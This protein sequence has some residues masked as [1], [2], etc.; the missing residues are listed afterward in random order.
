MPVRTFP[1][2]AAW[3]RR[4]LLGTAA[5][6]T[7]LA[8]L[9]PLYALERRPLA[10]PL[11]F[12]AHPD[13][14]IEWWYVTGALETAEA[15]LLW[16]FQLTFFRSRT[17]VAASH[18]SRFAA[19]QLVFA[20]AAL[21]DVAARRLRHD[22]RVARAGFGI[23]EAAVGDTR[24][25]LREWSLRRDAASGTYRARLRSDGADFALDLALVGD[26]PPLLQ[27]DAGW[28][29]KGPAEEQASRYY[30][31]PQLRA[32]GTLAVDGSEH[33]VHGTAWLDHEWS[34]ALLAPDAAGWDWIGINLA[35]GGALTA[36]RLRRRDGST[37]WAGGS[38]R[39]ADGTLRGFGADEVRFVP[40]RHWR[41]PA[42]QAAY[43]VE[44]TI[45]TPAGRHVLRALFDAQ[46]L[47]SRASTGAF[48]WEGLSVLADAASGRAL[49][50]GYL[51]MTGYAAPMRL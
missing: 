6:S 12:G 7:L 38:W 22:Q 39:A 42:S 37:L 41:S 23:A 24:L 19:T 35:D 32:S 5:A 40:G 26:T 1:R 44:W 10:F 14:R 4:R 27:G 31:R 34:D 45:E 9:P 46:E 33:A 51:E 2:D 3:H 43:P 30:S 48:Y 47:D 21:S 11:D 49:G 18:P 29:R 15:G 16:G 17:E 20:H 8:A 25:A 13:A 50:R 36:F 28:S